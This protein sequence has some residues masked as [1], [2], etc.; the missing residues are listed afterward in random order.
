MLPTAEVHY[1]VELVW[2]SLISLDHNDSSVSGV[3]STPRQSPFARKESAHEDHP[4]AHDPAASTHVRRSAAPQL[5]C[6][7]HSCVSALCRRFRQAFWDL[8]RASWPGA[9][10]HLSALSGPVET[11]GL[12]LHRADRVCPALLL[13]CDARTPGNAVVYCASPTPRHAAHHPQPS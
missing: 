8:P 3:E 6:A 13:S 4:L 7:Y 5:L 1:I 12:A 11:A 10:P 2:P 9:G